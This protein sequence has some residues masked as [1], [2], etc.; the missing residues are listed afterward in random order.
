MMRSLPVMRLGVM[1]A[2]GAI[3]AVLIAWNDGGPPVAKA[4]HTAEE[5]AAFAADRGG[6]GLAVGQ[7]T[8]FMAS[9]NCEGCHGHDPMEYAGV[10]SNGVDVNVVDDWRSSMMANSARDPFWRAKVSHEGLVN[11]AL[12]GI[13][14]DK[15]TSCHAP[16]GR[17][18][19]FLTGGGHYS[20]AEL[21]QD[22]IGLDGVSCVGCHIQ[23][24]DSLGLLFSGDLRFDTLGSPLYGPY[25]GPDDPLPLFGAPMTSFVGY[26]PQYGAHINS[27]TLCAGCHTLITET[28]DLQGNLTGG[29]F[30]EQATYHEWLNSRF[31][32]L[33][34]DPNGISC[35]GCHVPRN[36]DAVVIS[37]LY[38]FLQRRFPFG[39]HHFAGA[40]SFML[41][42]MKE[43]I[44][45]LGLTA[46]ETQFDSTIARTLRLLQ[47]QSLLMEATVVDRTADTAFIDVSLLNLAGHKFPSGYPSR[48][49]FM[50]LLVMDV[51]GQ[52]TLFRSG[53]FDDTYEVV[54]HDADWEPH[55]DVITSADQAQIYEH[56]MGDVNG[57]KTTVLL[58]ADQHLKDNRLAPEGFT[59]T[60]YAYDTCVVAG[61][62]ATDLDFNRDALGVEGN[63]GDIVHYHV[64]MG[65][66]TGL[67]NVVVRFWYQTAPARWNQELFS[68]SSAPIDSFETMYND[69]DRKPVLVKEVQLTDFSVGIDG[70]VDLGVRVF[71]NPVRDGVLR[72]SGLTGRVREVVVYDAGGRE[73][74]RPLLTS[75]TL[76]IPMHGRPGT[77]LVSIRT[78]E[79]TFV[80]RVV[81][82]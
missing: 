64:P 57:D 68:Y 5:L 81:V 38:L 23:S 36:D 45:P 27:A 37:A 72:V 29:S 26:E 3:V 74:A 80:E 49:A 58:R 39:M 34:G 53:G 19:K 40:N 31:N 42:L 7:N 32:D 24:A 55:H 52:D 47:D 8:Y 63:G 30:A 76:V 12:Q 50:E 51:S 56:V 41:G 79:R 13:I 43:N 10:D 2:L 17:H 21:E 59:T 62:P 65:G 73:V 20:I 25:G 16:M 61:V 28:V 69:A 4:Y 71:P 33:N 22:P 70:L 75:G 11:P 1:L 48:R 78:D 35:Q 6:Q 82:Q 18:D 60:H 54:G 66:Y 67:I 9:G 15:C 14:E 77:Y 44:G 46:N